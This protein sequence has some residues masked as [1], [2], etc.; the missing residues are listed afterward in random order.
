[1]NRNIGLWIDHKQ[2]YLIWYDKK[3][4]KVIPSNLEARTHYSGGTRIGGRYNQSVDSEL[5]HDDRYRNQLS[6]YY[7][8]V[9]ST[10]QHADSIIIM[11]PGEAK[12]ELE[13]TIRKYKGLSRKL[14]K[15]ETAD[16]MTKNQMVAYVREFFSK[17]TKH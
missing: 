11:G 3:M 1:M 5:K 16:K 17:I 12:F 13:R 8:Q 2:A 6:K 15:V 10:I 7:E 4:V 14:L 9:V